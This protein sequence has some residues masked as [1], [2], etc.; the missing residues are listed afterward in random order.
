MGQKMAWLLPAPVDASNADVKP[1]IG[2]LIGKQSLVHA[3]RPSDDTTAGTAPEP[4][5]VYQREDAPLYRALLGKEDVRRLEARVLTLE[6]GKFRSAMA[7]YAVGLTNAP[8]D[9]QHKVIAAL[10]QLLIVYALLIGSL[11][12]A[13]DPAAYVI[14]TGS[15]IESVQKCYSTLL[16][17]VFVLCCA[18]ITFIMYLLVITQIEPAHSLYRGLLYMDFTVIW[19]GVTWPILVG[20]V[21]LSCLAMIIGSCQIPAAGGAG[22]AA[23]WASAVPTRAYVDVGVKVAVFLIFNH[24]YPQGARAVAPIEM[25]FWT[26]WFFPHLNTQSGVVSEAQRL[27]PVY[28]RMILRTVYAH[29]GIKLLPG[30]TRFWADNAGPE[31]HQAD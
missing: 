2:K 5:A 6:S 20:C 12:T 25:F 16:G 26:R 1:P 13:I 15:A 9:A 28:A 23:G 18:V 24:H 10:S 21:V 11:L 31:Q 22:T 30:E 14:A 17:L 4:I 7:E 29:F 3:E 27:G 19:F 8:A